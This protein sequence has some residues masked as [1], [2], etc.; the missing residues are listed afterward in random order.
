[1]VWETSAGGRKPSKNLKGAGTFWIGYLAMFHL[2]GAGNS[3][4]TQLSAVAF[5]YPSRIIMRQDDSIRVNDNE[6]N[7]VRLLGRLCQ[8]LLKLK[9]A[10][11]HAHHA[12]HA[13]SG[14]RLKGP[15]ESGAFFQKQFGGEFLLPGNAMVVCQ[16]S[17]SYSHCLSS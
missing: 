10:P 9:T 7:N 2:L 17:L 3:F 11:M 13:R 1:M 16:T 15:Y 4:Q 8:Q 12:H 5:S 14:T 6:M